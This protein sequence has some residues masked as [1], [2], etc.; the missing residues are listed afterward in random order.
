VGLLTRP[1]GWEQKTTMER[2]Q[3]RKELSTILPG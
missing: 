3:H 1:S 2:R